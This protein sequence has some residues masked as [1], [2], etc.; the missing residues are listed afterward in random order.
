MAIQINLHKT[1]R[2]YTG[3]KESVAVEGRTIG[4][5]L[6]DLIRQ[7]PPLEKE[8]FGKN[9]KLSGIVEVYLNGATAYPD[10]LAK[11]VKEGDTIQLVYFLAGG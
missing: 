10:E 4:E 6:K 2:Q 7:Y 1:H 5:C 11:P 3:G 9:G 8:V